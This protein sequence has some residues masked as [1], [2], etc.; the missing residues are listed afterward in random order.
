MNKTRKQIA[1]TFHVSK[2]TVYR[3]IK[4]NDILSVEEQAGE[5]GNFTRTYDEQAQ[6]I[7]KSALNRSKPSEPVHEPL[8]NHSEPLVN[9]S[10]PVRES[11]N[12]SVVNRSE[13]LYESV[14]ETLKQELEQKNNEIN[15]L[16]DELEK[17]QKLLDQEQQLHLVTKQLLLEKQEQETEPGA[18]QS[19][20][21][22]WF[23]KFKKGSRDNE[24][25]NSENE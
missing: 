9:H 6:E 24:T 2:S 19:R 10:E 21:G 23:R 7:I 15:R 8:V 17:Q 11:V 16:H 18:K 14:I 4:D 12:E 3:I 13:P 1:D 25:V 5:Q 22:S 20:I